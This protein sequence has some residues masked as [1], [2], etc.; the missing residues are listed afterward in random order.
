MIVSV[1]A[2]NMFSHFPRFYAL[3]KG[4]DNLGVDFIPNYLNDANIGISLKTPVGRNGVV[5]HGYYFMTFI[6]SG[7]GWESYWTQLASIFPRSYNL[8]TYNYAKYG[9]GFG[10]Q[11]TLFN[12][13]VVDI[14]FGL[15]YFDMSGE[16][17]KVYLLPAIFEQGEDQA[18]VFASLGLGIGDHAQSKV[19]DDQA[20]IYGITLDI[21]AILKNS[22]EA[23]L[24]FGNSGNSLWHAHLRYGT[25]EEG[26]INVTSATK[27]N[28]FY[29]GI[30][31][32]NYPGSTEKKE[33]LY[34][35]GDFTT[36]HARAEIRKREDDMRWVTHKVLYDPQRITFSMGFTKHLNS[37]YLID[38]YISNAYTFSPGS[39][40]KYYAHPDEA[41]GITTYIGIK[42]GFLKMKKI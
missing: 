8:N 1:H 16:G 36:G 31:Y 21:N 12:S 37:L 5:F 34:F 7:R 23:G 10:R 13:S 40:T 20:L 42:L 27:F 26:Q 32:R 28:N 38:G 17:E 18:Y 35:A 15:G 19:K 14:N 41:T 24:L 22:I 4:F 6:E 25:R 2:S 39:T 9:I 33:G 11:W 29:A 3:D 30:Q